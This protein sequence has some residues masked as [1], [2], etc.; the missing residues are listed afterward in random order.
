MF[1]EERLREIVTHQ[2]REEEELGESAGGSGHLGFSDFDLLKIARPVAFKGR[3]Q[4]LWKLNFE[5]RITIETE[6]TYEPDNPPDEYVYSKSI[7]IDRDGVVVDQEPKQLIRT[8]REFL[9]SDPDDFD[10]DEL[11]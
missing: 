2:I 5:Y 3:Q 7:T 8:N 1:S 10:E 6:F 11:D 9:M 4:G